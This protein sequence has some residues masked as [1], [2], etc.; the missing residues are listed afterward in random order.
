MSGRHS[1]AGTNGIP[2]ETGRTYLRVVSECAEDGRVRVDEVLWPDGRRFPAVSTTHIR[3]LGRWEMGNVVEQY[4]VAFK[5]PGRREVRRTI[6]W[7][8]GRWFTSQARRRG[9]ASRNLSPGCAKTNTSP[10]CEK[11]VV[12]SLTIGD[13]GESTRDRAVRRERGWWDL[14]SASRRRS[15]PSRGP[16]ARRT[17]PASRRRRSGR[18]HRPAELRGNSARWVV[19]SEV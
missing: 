6:W 8:R 7:E 3:T 14:A 16:K 17:R 18:R 11:N 10:I 4:E 15:P 12:P 1:L 9:R 5:R 13:E 2:L 19:T